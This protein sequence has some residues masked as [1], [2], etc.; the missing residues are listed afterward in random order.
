LQVRQFLGRARLR[1]TRGRIGI[2]D[3]LGCHNYFAIKIFSG[4]VL[5]SASIPVLEKDRPPLE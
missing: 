5:V 3:F 1:D 2:L 4:A